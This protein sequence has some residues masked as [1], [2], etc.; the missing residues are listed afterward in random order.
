MNVAWFNKAKNNRFELCANAMFR[1]LYVDEIKFK[2][3]RGSQS[4]FVEMIMV[5][6]LCDEKYIVL[7]GIFYLMT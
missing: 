1:W 4:C 6:K 3:I 2:F 5:G 7:W